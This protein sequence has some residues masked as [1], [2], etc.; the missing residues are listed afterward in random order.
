MHEQPISFLSVLGLAAMVTAVGWFAELL[1]AY[2]AEQMTGAPVKERY[3]P[4]SRHMPLMLFLIFVLCTLLF[5]AILKPQWPWDPRTQEQEWEA[6]GYVGHLLSGTLYGY[7]YDETDNTWYP[8]SE[9]AYVD[10]RIPDIT[11]EYADFRSAS[12]E[13]NVS[14]ELREPW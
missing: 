5:S 12:D 10:M 1:K 11:V 13:G 7:E 3:S 8:I 14:N 4:F 2:R 9:D 6:A